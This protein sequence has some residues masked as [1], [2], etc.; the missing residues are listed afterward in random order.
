MKPRAIEFAVTAALVLILMYAYFVYLYCNVLG[1]GDL[2]SA[3]AFLWEPFAIT[4]GFIA[5]LGVVI[6]KC[7]A[8]PK[9]DH[10]PCP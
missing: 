10:W 6:F 2:C 5:L 4:A 8:L 1:S 7:C 3:V 9:K